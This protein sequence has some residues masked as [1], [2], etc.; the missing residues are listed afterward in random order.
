[1]HV[2]GGGGIGKP[3]HSSS[4]DGLLSLYCSPAGQTGF[5]FFLVVVTVK[6][7]MHLSKSLS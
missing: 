5:F 2:S 1:M 3:G 4:E 7:E 6:A